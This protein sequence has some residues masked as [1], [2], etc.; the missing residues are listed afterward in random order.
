MP[1]VDIYL[2]CCGE[3]LVVLRNTYEHVKK[4]EY[5]NFKVHVLDDKNLK[6]VKELAKEFGYNYI[7]RSDR[8]YMKKAG[9]L[10]NAFQITNGEFFLILDADFCPRYDI[11]SETLPYFCFYENLAILQTPQFFRVKSNQTWVEKAAGSVQE[12]FYRLIQVNRNRFH[13]SICVGTSAIYRRKA[14]IPFGGTYEIEHSEDLHTG[15][16]ATNHGWLVKYLPLNL[17]MGMCPDNLTTFFTQQYRWASGSTSLCL[18]KIFWKSNLTVIQKICYLSG[19]FYYSAT[20]LRNRM[21][22]IFPMIIF[23]ANKVSTSSLVIF[24]D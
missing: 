23:A 22:L 9:N 13:S 19:M 18:N 20:A 15:F 10:R 1:L 17:S 5:P 14:L 3:P 24:G 12:L 4:I 8:P 16:N 11:F 7:V 21:R 6:E 2:P